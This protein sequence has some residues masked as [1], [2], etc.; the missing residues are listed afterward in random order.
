MQ[1]YQISFD[2]LLRNVTAVFFVILFISILAPMC[3]ARLLDARAKGRRWWDWTVGIEY[4][5]PAGLSPAECARFLSFTT[6]VQRGPVATLLDLE[7]RGHL[8]IM[9]VP[10]DQRVVVPGGGIRRWRIVRRSGTDALRPFEAASLERVFAGASEAYL[11]MSTVKKAGGGLQAANYYIDLEMIEKGL[12][13]QGHIAERG[14]NGNACVSGFAIWSLAILLGT[15]VPPLI[16]AS[17][18]CAYVASRRLDW[19]KGLSPQGRALRYH[20]VGFRHYLRKVYARRVDW[21]LREDV[22]DRQLPYA[23][24][25]GLGTRPW[26]LV[27]KASHAQG[28]P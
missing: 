23:V 15:L 1:E 24:A 12:A 25:V 27:A 28:K 7:E 26:E 6:L 8:D 22:S 17:L 14:P 19:W 5:P 9:D 16:F 18:G 11:E 10:A 20:I 3:L 21:S 4:E 13:E 2:D